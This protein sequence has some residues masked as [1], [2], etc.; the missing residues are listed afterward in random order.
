[1][2]SYCQKDS[3]CSREL[4]YALILVMCLQSS[5]DEIKILFTNSHLLGEE[6]RRRLSVNVNLL[7]CAFT[8]KHPSREKYACTFHPIH[9]SLDI[10][11]GAFGYVVRMR[12]WGQVFSVTDWCLIS[13]SFASFLFVSW[14]LQRS[15]TMVEGYDLLCMVCF[16]PGFYHQIKKN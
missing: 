4:N 6:Y 3:S 10:G 7:K 13:F 11:C 15:A 2:V 16:F 8:R 9:L 14:L 1:M 5:A 12:V